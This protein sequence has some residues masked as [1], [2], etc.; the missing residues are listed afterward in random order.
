MDIDTVC[1][2]GGLFLKR[3]LQRRTCT[4]GINNKRLMASLS[5]SVHCV[6]VVPVAVYVE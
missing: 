3:E 5:S 1:C 2:D 4:S 6:S